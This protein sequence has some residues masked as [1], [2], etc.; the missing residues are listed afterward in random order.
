MAP[1]PGDAAGP[2]YSSQERSRLVA[3]LEILV[4]GVAVRH[5]PGAGLDGGC[6][7]GGDQHGANGDGRVEVPGEVEVAD[8]ARVGASLGGLEL[9]DDLHGAHLR[10]TGD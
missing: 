4:G 10:R 2:W 1:G 9:V 5:D 7:V 3:A 6:A 8:H